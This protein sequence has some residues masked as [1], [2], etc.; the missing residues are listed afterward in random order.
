MILPENISLD[1]E[2]YCEDCKVC[3]PEFFTI[4]MDGYNEVYL[5]CKM[6]KGCESLVNFM[7]NKS[8]KEEVDE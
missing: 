4:E 8:K 3:D 1:F 7:H 5:R 2:D 6:A